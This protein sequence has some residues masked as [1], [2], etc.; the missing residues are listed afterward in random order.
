M[1]VSN[2]PNDAKAT[3]RGRLKDFV[4]WRQDEGN[5]LYSEAASQRGVVW[6]GSAEGA[7]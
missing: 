5:P 3:D 2:N 6:V 7:K 1:I 4:T